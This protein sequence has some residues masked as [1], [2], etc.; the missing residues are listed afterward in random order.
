MTKEEAKQYDDL[1][2]SSEYPELLKELIEKK[3]IDKYY[4]KKAISNINDIDIQIPEGKL[5]L[6]AISLISR[7]TTPKK[8]PVQVLTRLNFILNKSVV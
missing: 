2:N 8:R 6:V 7:A 1:I 5:L 3:F 4:N